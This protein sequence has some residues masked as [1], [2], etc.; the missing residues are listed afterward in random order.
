MTRLELARL[1]MDPWWFI[2]RLRIVTKTGRLVTFKD[3]GLFPEQEQTLRAL[4]DGGDVLVEKSRQMG[5]TTIVVAFCLWK[6][7]TAR[8]SYNVLMVMHE[9][10]STLRFA[11]QLRV[12]IKHLPPSIRPVILVD[13]SSEITLKVGNHISM[14]RFT[15]A[16]GRSGAKGFTFRL[17]A[18]SE[19]AHYPMG[20]SAHRKADP[21]AEGVDKE[22]YTSARS[23]LPTRDVDP[24]ARLVIESTPGPPYGLYHDL[25]KATQ[26]GGTEVDAA[27]TFLFFPWY[28]FPQYRREVPEGFEVTSEEQELLGTHPEM[29]MENIAFR[30]HKLDV[31][32]YSLRKFR[33]DFPTTWSEPFLVSGGVWFDAEVIN[34][35]SL[36]LPPGPPTGLRVY[37]PPRHGA[38]YFHGY[39]ASGGTQNDSG[40]LTVLN[41]A[42]EQ[43]LVWSS[44]HHQPRQQAEMI[45]DIWLQYPG[46]VLVECGNKYGN[47]V[48]ERLIELGV[49]VYV[50]Q[51]G[52]RFTTTKS[53]KATLMDYARHEVNEQLVDIEDPPTVMELGKF[54]EFPDGTLA[55]EAGFH[56]DHVMSLAFALWCGRRHFPADR[57]RENTAD[58]TVAERVAV[59][60]KRGI[61]FGRRR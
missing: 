22:F 35:L 14:I 27:W 32:G 44:D 20:S 2:L 50:D 43:C 55:A 52:D 30:R 56:D 21:E 26:Q 60:R 5:I 28:K 40:V 7:I 13:N 53:T 33:K 57:W 46:I 49:T 61:R 37:Q 12:H 36:R 11:Q 58:G 47:A 6:V 25:V 15:M 51:Y 8:S 34:A 54:R 42:A 10:T 3:I 24:E 39:D 48:V 4:I 16:G 23:T 31:E 1:I 18:L 38:M 41:K 45:K 29:T 9:H 59:L 19:A 17:I